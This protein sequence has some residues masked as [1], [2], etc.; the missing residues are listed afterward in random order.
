MAHVRSI[1]RVE[2]RLSPIYALLA[3]PP[4]Y[5]VFADVEGLFSGGDDKGLAAGLLHAGP[6]DIDEL[7]S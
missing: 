2:L 3:P 4:W 7:L 1:D 5:E 6:R